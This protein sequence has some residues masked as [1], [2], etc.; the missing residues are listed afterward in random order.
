[1]NVIDAR[2]TGRARSGGGNGD[3]LRCR[4][5][6]E[7]I[8]RK[9]FERALRVCPG[10]GRH[11]RMPAPDRIRHLL[12]PGPVPIENREPPTDPLG[13]TDGRSYG[14]RLEEAREHSGLPE[15]IVCVRGA[16][17]GNPL[18]AAV[19]DFRFLGG[20][21][22]CGVGERIAAAAAAAIT[23]KLPMLF[24]TASGGARMQEGTLALMQLAKA[25]AAMADLDEAGCP[26]ICL[27]T[28]PTYGGVAASFATQ[29]DIIIAEPGAHLGFAGPRVIEQIT[30]QGLPDGFQTAEHL[31][32][33]G[34]IDAVQPRSVLRHLLARLLATLAGR[35]DPGAPPPERTGP[36]AASLIRSAERLPD[37]D[38]WDV[39]QA[40]RHRDRP[41]A[42]E[43]VGHLVEDFHELHGDRVGGDCKAVIAGL[44]R[45]PA[46]T[47]ALI[48][49][50]KGHTTRE[51]MARNFGMPTPAG[52]RKA[53]RVMRLAAKL[54]VPVI[55]L[56]DTPGAHPGPEAEDDGQAWAIAA[57]LR[58][59][60]ELTVAVVA[61]IIGE[62]GSGGALAFAV[63]DRVLM[64]ENSTY[65]VISPEGCAA[66]L[67]K[68]SAAAPRSARA[69]RGDARTQLGLGVVDAVVREPEGG[70]HRDPEA[71]TGLLRDAV[72]QTLAEISALD[73]RTRITRRRERFR[74]LGMGSAAGSELAGDP[75]GQGAG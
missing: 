39:V 32:A 40:A 29:A 63:A 10:C 46:G 42:L 74:R 36:G 73:P 67:W 20:S 17:E 3:W 9:R 5:C 66:I 59:M 1:M 14:D 13:F 25:S 28:D 69:L 24:V 15:A 16:I 50:Q 70:A 61:V 11:E 21:L 62:G 68:D 71:A 56:I 22:G 8:Y 52:Y 53:S 27:V 12:D 23:G 6:L 54:G 30:R 7:L 57:A 34:M 64:L 41:T 47:V 48:G 75:A 45:G 31:L 35:P 4:G 43:Y 37:R 58:L 72:L 51:L 44:G 26:T 38:P 2:S 18:V 65:S 60:C 33:R 49:H 19:M 55:A